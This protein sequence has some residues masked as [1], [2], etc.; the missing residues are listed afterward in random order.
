VQSRLGLEEAALDP[1]PL[2][3]RPVGRLEF[4]IEKAREVEWEYYRER[5]EGGL[6]FDFFPFHYP[7]IKLYTRDQ[8]TAAYIYYQEK[9]GHASL[10]GLRSSGELIITDLISVADYAEAMG[11]KYLELLISAYDPLMQRLAYEAGFLP[12]A[13]FPA[14]KIGADGRREDYLITSCTFVPPHFKGLRMTPETRPFLQAYYR[15]Y[16][17]KLWEDMQ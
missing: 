7:N 3:P 2:E 6:L 16:T 11:V 1:S 10:L 8:K 5:D 9:D 15:I 4:L 17:N 12:T 13:Y 14:A